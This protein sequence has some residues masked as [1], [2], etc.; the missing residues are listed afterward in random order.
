[1]GEFQW[2]PD[3]YRALMRQEV[4][5]YDR[6][7]AELVEATRGITAR[8]ILELGTGTGETTRR[9]LAAHPQAG[10]HGIDSSPEMLAAARSAL[11]G[12]DVRLE[13]ARI[14]DPLPDGPF[15]LIVSALTI[16]H[17]AGPD[18]AALF[19]RIAVLLPPG[20]RFVVAD[21]VVPED[22]DDVVT[23][24]DPDDYDQPSSTAEQLAWLTAAGLTARAQWA[25]RD[26]AVLVGDRPADSIGGR[27]F[28]AT[29]FYR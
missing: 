9:I 25:H 18:K 15:D 7:Q 5:D 1:M 24:I 20:G 11:S 12:Y 6:L 10:L 29:G 19:T 22:P 26:L 28:A 23:P 27:E 21:I 2:E 16:H 4:P 17:L 13:V 8:S 14:E 3:S